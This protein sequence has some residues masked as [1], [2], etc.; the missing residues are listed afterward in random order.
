MSRRRIGTDNAS[1][2]FNES[3]GNPEMSGNQYYICAARVASCTLAISLFELDAAVV[4][5]L[6]ANGERGMY[7]FQCGRHAEFAC[8][9]HGFRSVALVSPNSHGGLKHH[10]TPIF[11]SCTTICTVFFLHLSAIPIVTVNRR[12]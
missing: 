2:V 8:H 7:A 4:C 12:V 6:Q 10:Q 1:C 9:S 11:R 3:L 5:A